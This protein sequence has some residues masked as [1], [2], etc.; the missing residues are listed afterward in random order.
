MNATQLQRRQEANGNVRVLW[1]TRKNNLFLEV[2]T[3][4]TINDSDPRGREM[5]TPENF[6]QP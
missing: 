6:R 4:A 3:I 5:V 2:A 1:V